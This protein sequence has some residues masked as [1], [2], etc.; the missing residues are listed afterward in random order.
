M[1]SAL[2]SHS[3]HSS[4]RCA[5]RSS[6]YFVF[7]AMIGVLLIS[8]CLAFATCPRVH[9]YCRPSTWL[10]LW[11]CTCFGWRINFDIA[12]LVVISQQ[13]APVES[14]FAG[15]GDQ[16]SVILAFLY[17]FVSTLTW[18]SF[19]LVAVMQTMLSVSLC[20]GS[21]DGILCSSWIGTTFSHAVWLFH[22]IICIVEIIPLHLESAHACY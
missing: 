9:S 14:D 1:W 12:K 2:C 16:H 19:S 20:L 22:I 15:I 4:L 6:A 11:C 3:S 17:F 10:S 7:H 13:W 8:V 5:L 18:P 21:T